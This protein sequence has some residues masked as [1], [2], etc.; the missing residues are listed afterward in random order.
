MSFNDPPAWIPPILD[1]FFGRIYGFLKGL[2]LPIT[3]VLFGIGGL[4]ALIATKTNHSDKV[5][6]V[7]LGIMV[8]A[9]ILGLIT[10][11]ATV[12]GY[13]TGQA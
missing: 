1:A 10:A 9:F 11:G 13:I 7:L 5:H 3:I 6:D 2:S 4:M 8:S 12:Y